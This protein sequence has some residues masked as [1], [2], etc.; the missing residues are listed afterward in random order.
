VAVSFIGGENRNG[1]K[2]CFL[3]LVYVE[4]LFF[5][6]LKALFLYVSYKIIFMH[7]AQILIYCSYRSKNNVLTGTKWDQHPKFRILIS[8]VIYEISYLRFAT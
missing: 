1:S 2:E 6:I 3:F 8:S 4:H 7:N 5:S